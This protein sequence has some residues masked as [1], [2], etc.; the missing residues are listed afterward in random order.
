MA[1][2][3]FSFSRGGRMQEDDKPM[4]I[5]VPTNLLRGFV[6]IIDS[7]SMLGAADSVYVSQSA[8]SLQIKRLE[9]LVQQPLFVREGRRL[10]LTDRGQV[11]LNYAR[12]LLALHDE[13]VAAVAAPDLAGP[14][15]IGMV[16]DFAETLLAGLLAQFAELHPDVHLFARIA[17]TAEMLDLL[18]RGQLDIVLGYGDVGAPN[19]FGAAPMVWHGDAAA[20]ERDVVPLVVLEKPCR[21]REAA[22]AALDA[23]G[24]RW[25]LAVETPNLSTLRA[26]VT[27]GLGITCRTPIFLREANPI[28]SGLPPLPSIACRV[29]RGPDLSGPGAHLADLLQTVVA[30]TISQA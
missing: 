16:Q 12:R 19:A 22:I 15:R 13:A 29:E 11:L 8:L 23:S 6:A 21:F 18:D 10:V 9:E 28:M 17:G 5:N 25:R 7:G 4:A 30:T 26:A 20:A 24:R 2:I 3:G 27:A 1:G 14:V